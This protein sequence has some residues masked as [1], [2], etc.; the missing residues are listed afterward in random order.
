MDLAMIDVACDAPVLLCEACGRE[1]AHMNAF[2]NHVGN[3]RHRKKRMASALET[4]KEKYRNKKR[5]LDTA[6]T[7]QPLQS[8]KPSQQPI[9]PAA[10]EVRFECYSHFVTIIRPHPFHVARI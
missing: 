4:A 10:F 6:S 7:I 1:F 5:R 2:S 8:D 3:C 9:A